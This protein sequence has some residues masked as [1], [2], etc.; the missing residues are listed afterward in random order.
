MEY[1]SAKN[2]QQNKETK[3]HMILQAMKNVENI[4]C[5]LLSEKSIWEGNYMIATIWL[6]GRDNKMIIGC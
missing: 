1:Y 5:I 6:F 3:T 2:K 4:K